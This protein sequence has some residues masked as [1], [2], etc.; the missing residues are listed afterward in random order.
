MHGR[1]R[2]SEGS[3][4]F[5]TTAACITVMNALQRNAMPADAFLAN[6]SIE[7]AV[8]CRRQPCNTSLH[9]RASGLPG[10][11]EPLAIDVETWVLAPDAFFGEPQRRCP[12]INLTLWPVFGCKRTHRVEGWR[13]NLAS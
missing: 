6:D 1:S 7:I 5:R 8:R 4:R 12:G 9:A 10:S 11:R 2:V 3:S 13:I